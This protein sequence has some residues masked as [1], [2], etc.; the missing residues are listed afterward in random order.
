M[1]LFATILAGAAVAGIIYYLI[2]KEGAEELLADAREAAKD[3]Y[4]KM[5]EGLSDVTRKVSETM[6]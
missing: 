6:A 3:A 5:N 1:K 2:D 4:D